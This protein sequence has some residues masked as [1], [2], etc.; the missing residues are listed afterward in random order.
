MTT[1]IFNSAEEINANFLRSINPK[2]SPY[3]NKKFLLSYEASNPKID[4]R[5][6]G[7]NENNTPKALAVVQIIDLSVDAILDNIKIS[8]TLKRFLNLFFCRDYIKIMF[9]GNV[10]LSGN[11]GISFA[12]TTDRGQLISRLGIALDGMAQT[13]KPLHAIFVKDFNEE[14][15]RYTKNFSPFG[16]TKIRVEPNMMIHLRQE[17]ETFEDFKAALKSKYRVKANKADSNSQS[18]ELKT[19][20]V[21]DIKRYKED[22]QTLYQN[23]IDNANFNAQ[24]LNLETY[25]R[26]KTEFKYDFIVQGY[27]FEDKLVG[28]LSALKRDNSLD[29]HFIGLNYALNKTH[30]IYPRILNDYVRLGIEH[31]VKVI[32]LGRTASEIKTTVG[33]QPMDLS[34]YIKHKNPFIN[35]LIRPL[36]KRIKIKSFK[37]H[38]PFK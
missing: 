21:T 31:R 35:T 36:L 3:F 16:Y 34:C 25:I 29:A 12:S 10:F 37:Q 7:I 14:E 26:L 20:S 4:I 22:L 6:I 27:F 13:V 5:Y 28:F 1:T 17:W 2:N 11:Y 23:T 9:C 30:A 24:I 32:N 18:L 33:A 19:C 8:S 15:L 38:H